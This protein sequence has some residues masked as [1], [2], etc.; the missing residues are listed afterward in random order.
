M[1]V[2]ANLNQLPG[3]QVDLHPRIAK[4]NVTQQQRHHLLTRE[5]TLC[6]SMK[7][8][9]YARV[10]S[11]GRPKSQRQAG[12][13]ITKLWCHAWTVNPSYLLGL[14]R[15]WQTFAKEAGAHQ[16]SDLYSQCR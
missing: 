16:C 9:C 11:A 10:C 13:W 15:R 14:H 12:P 6:K 1:L 4:L 5:A 3:A 2:S 8:H 7:A